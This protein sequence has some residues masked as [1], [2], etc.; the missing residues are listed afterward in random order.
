MVFG[1]FTKVG[2]LEPS[3]EMVGTSR[4]PIAV[5]PDENRLVQLGPVLWQDVRLGMTRDEVQGVRYEAVRSLKDEKLG[6]GTKAELAIPHLKLGTHDFR[7][8]FYFKD[9][10][11]KQITI[12][13]NRPV[14]AA[15]P[16]GS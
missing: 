5:Q 1:L 16:D 7:V 15:C 14:E 13:S 8:L 9:A 3:N 11:L 4:M 2:K 6:D 12:K 10:V